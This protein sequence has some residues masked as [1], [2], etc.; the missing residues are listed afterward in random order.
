[1]QRGV[2]GCGAG[3]ATSASRRRPRCSTAAAT[4]ASRLRPATPL[5]P[6]SGHPAPSRPTSA[7]FFTVFTPTPPAE[8]Y[9]SRMRLIFWTAAGST[10]GE[11]RWGGEG[12]V[13]PVRRLLQDAAHLLGRC[14]QHPCGRMGARRDGGARRGRCGRRQ[15]ARGTARLPASCSGGREGEPCCQ[16]RHT[17]VSQMW[18]QRRAPA[19]PGCHPPASMVPMPTS[20][21]RLPRPPASPASCAAASC[22]V[23]RGCGEQHSDGTA[24]G[25]AHGP[26]RAAACSA[27]VRWRSAAAPLQPGQHAC[28]AH[29]PAVM[30]HPPTSRTNPQNN[31]RTRQAQQRCKQLPASRRA[32]RPPTSCVPSACTTW[33][34]L[35]RMMWKMRSRGCTRICRGAAGAG[36]RAGK[37]RRGAVGRPCAA[38]AA[39]RCPPAPCLG[40]TKPFARPQWNEPVNKP[41]PEPAERHPARLP[42]GVVEDH[43]KGQQHR[44][45]HARQ[46]HVVH[47]AVVVGYREEGAAEMRCK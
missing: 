31:E 25:H 46:Q 8:V 3:R 2:R 22:G 42:D 14:G 33:L 1:M 41:N 24:R 17:S 26:C 36:G 32:P 5:Q 35:V 44:D 27:P 38:C 45:H 20:S 39:G 40:C 37:G 11:G 34:A 29:P 7:I 16:H 43:H 47:R 21:L 6:S 18:K 4:P 10:R 30:R 12:A 19:R 9:C 23:G 28:P 13:W 15:A